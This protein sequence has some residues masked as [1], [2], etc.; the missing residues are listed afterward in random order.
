MHNA[1]EPLQ[2]TLTEADSHHIFCVLQSAY[3]DDCPYLDY[4]EVRE[5]DTEADKSINFG[6]A[7]LYSEAISCLNCKAAFDLAVRALFFL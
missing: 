5:N 3:G 2:G 6:R 1:N 7:S 4:N